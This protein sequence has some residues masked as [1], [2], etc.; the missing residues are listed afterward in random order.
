MKSKHI[1]LKLNENEIAILKIKKTINASGLK[2][3]DDN[4]IIIDPDIK[5]NKIE[6]VK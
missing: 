4:K 1:I 2:M 6:E 5:W 3:L